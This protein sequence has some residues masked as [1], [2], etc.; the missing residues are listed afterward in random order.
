MTELTILDILYISLIA[1][2]SV[3]WVLL[4]IVLV[5]LIKI[6]WVVQEISAYYYTV[7]E[8][9]AMYARIPEIIKEKVFELIKWDKKDNK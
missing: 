4:A 1:F 9:L 7:K 5:R 8:Y 6:L 2:V 3:I